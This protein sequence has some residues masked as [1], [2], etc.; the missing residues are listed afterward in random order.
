[1]ILTLCNLLLV[2]PY[3]SR[4]FTTLSMRSSTCI[5]FLI[6]LAMPAGLF[7]QQVNA[8]ARVTDVSG[9]NLTVS[10]VLEVHDQFVADEQ[11]IL[12]QVQA[13]VLSNT[14]NSESF[15][16]ITSAGTAGLYEVLEI[17]STL[18]SGGNLL[19]VTLKNPPANTFDTGSNA[20]LQLV[21]FPQLGSPNYTTP[22][23]ITCE[24]WNGERGGIVAFQV[25]GTL[26]VAHN[27]H[28]DGLGF[29]GGT[30]SVDNHNSS[31][32]NNTIF[33]SHS[34]THGEKG[35]G[36]HRN[37]NNDYRYS[38]GKMVSGG[39]GGSSHNGGGGG[40][41]NFTGGGIGGSGWNGTSTGCSPSTSGL[42]GL[43]LSFYIEP[44]RVFMGGGGGGGQQNNSVGTVGAA[45]GGLVF[46][47]A[48]TLTTPESACSLRISANGAT[49]PNAGNDGSGGGGAGG[50]IV[51]QVNDFD[52]SDVCPLAIQANGGAG[53]SVTSSTHAG[54]G[55]GGQGTI[56]YPDGQP[57]M[58]ITSNT[59]NGAGGCDNSSCTQAAASGLGLNNTGILTGL[60]SLLSA[61]SIDLTARAQG[62]RVNLEWFVTQPSHP[63]AIPTRVERSSNLEGWDAIVEA[64]V[65]PDFKQS[66]TDE[67]G[68]GTWYYRASALDGSQVKSQVR[69]V[70]I[71]PEGPMILS[72]FPN[73]AD[74]IAFLRFSGPLFGECTVIAPD[75]RIIQNHQL[76]GHTELTLNLDYIASGIY[77]IE[78]RADDQREMLRLKVR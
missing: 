31:D 24:A 35:E 42:G 53:G 47:K 2:L 72:Y 27:I 67:P 75:G 33:W 56:V 17:E 21:T 60:Q 45:G 77:L 34:S 40:G 3:T 71:A 28:A 13:N 10:D 39:G 9:V 7:A 25:T 55:G 22:N 14:T 11:V 19:Q 49:A 52:V 38:R 57:T 26:T 41:G 5:F 65:F 16:D 64:Y 12:V 59:L 23:A 50:S 44:N 70:E 54:G 46:I 73:P 6:S 36:I 32:C 76:N 8:Y 58:N 43:G 20:R 1:M 69:A 48:E 63:S 15:G 74:N 62:K 78:L 66:H 37:T 18:R 61:E 29:R 30:R 4:I 68:S 51:F